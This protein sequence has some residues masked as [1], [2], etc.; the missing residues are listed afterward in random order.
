L[1][2]IFCQF[3]GRKNVI[4][5]DL[6]HLFQAVVVVLQEQRAVLNQADSYNGNH[7]D[8]M[9]AIFQDAVLAAQAKPS[10]DLAGAMDYASRLLRQRSSDGSAQVYAAGL[11]Q[12]ARQFRK[13][14]VTLDDLVSYAQGVI[15]E[16][17]NS[18][19]GE[20]KFDANEQG[21]EKKDRSGSVL[22]ALLAGLAGWQKVE[23][24][25]S[26]E[27]DRLGMG[28]LFEVG[29][30]Y[31]QA[32]QRGGSKTEILADAAVSV[33]PL[34]RVPHRSQ[35]GKIAIQAL[36]QAMRAEPDSA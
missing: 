15:K 25:E 26:G 4:S 12:F 3:T 18:P 16:G 30:A 7:G 28:Y 6:P 31:M 22:K 23:S 14:Q 21:E 8:H 32:K 11:E 19:G 29:I 13:H 17:E 1:F 27:D 36:L 20:N 33:C 10:N 34:N 5:Y 24:G 9:V 35:S 2:H